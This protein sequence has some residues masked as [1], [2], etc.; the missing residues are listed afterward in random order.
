[1]DSFTKIV[2]LYRKNNGYVHESLIRKRNIDGIYGL[3]INEKI[4]KNTLLIRT[5]ENL[6]LKIKNKIINTH[7]KISVSNFIS[8]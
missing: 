5:P 1:M 7:D 6:I 8:P 2:D 3:Y 4:E